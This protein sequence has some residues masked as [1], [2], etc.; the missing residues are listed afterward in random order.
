MKKIISFCILAIATKFAFGQSAD[1]VT[2]PSYAKPERELFEY[3]AKNI[4]NIASQRNIMAAEVYLAVHISSGGYIEKIDTLSNP[5]KLNLHEVIKAIE[6]C[7]NWN[8]AKV[9]GAPV[10][11]IV[12]MCFGFYVANEYKGD[13][14]RI[15][16][17]HFESIGNEISLILPKYTVKDYKIGLVGGTTPQL[18]LKADQGPSFEERYKTAME[19]IEKEDYENAEKQ[20]SELYRGDPMNGRTLYLRG[21]CKHK[22]NNLKGACK[23]W[24]KAAKFNSNS[25]KQALEQYCN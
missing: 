19:S 21:V 14:S 5:R 16:S 1:S 22:Q 2:L 11:S 9:N 10:K 4:R 12:G 7:D 24:K 25:A 8:P 6:H 23:D 13:I 18:H 17:S 20:L 15:D 3:F